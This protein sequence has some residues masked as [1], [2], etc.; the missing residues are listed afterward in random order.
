MQLATL[1]AQITNELVKN[2]GKQTAWLFLRASLPTDRYDMPHW[3][4]DG[5]FYAPESPNDPVLK[6]VLTLM[7]PPTLF[8]PVP[9]ELRKTAEKHMHNRPY[10]KSFCQTQNILSPAVG[11]GALFI[12]NRSAGVPAL[13]SEPPDAV[14]PKDSREL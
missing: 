3:H 5:R 14:Y 4:T 11:E 9:L 8:Y 2:S 13:H 12:S 1:I 6:F 7:G 10:M